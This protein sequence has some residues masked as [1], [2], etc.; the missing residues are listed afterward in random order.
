MVAG[1]SLTRWSRAIIVTDRVLS[2]RCGQE[3]FRVDPSRARAADGPRGAR[4]IRLRRIVSAGDDGMPGPSLCRFIPRTARM[5]ARRRRF[6]FCI[7]RVQSVRRL[8]LFL[9]LRN[10]VIV[11]GLA[12][13][14]AQGRAAPAHHILSVRGFRGHTICR[15]GFNLFKLLPPPFPSGRHDPGDRDASAQKIKDRLGGLHRDGGFRTK[16]E[17]VSHLAGNLL[18]G[19]EVMQLA[20]VVSSNLRRNLLFEFYLYLAIP[21]YYNNF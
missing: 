2:R 1:A 10:F 7:E 14:V 18:G 21:I 5:A 12:A 6:Q 17:R 15:P 16:I 20:K 8:F 9:Q 3:N 13:G 11:C 19:S 4:A